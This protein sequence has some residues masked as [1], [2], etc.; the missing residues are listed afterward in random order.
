MGN[1]KEEVEAFLKCYEDAM[2]SHDF[3]RVRELL[4]ED[5]VYWFSEGSFSSLDE[6]KGAFVST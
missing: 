5:A 1:V 2:N 4:S 6:I 3:S